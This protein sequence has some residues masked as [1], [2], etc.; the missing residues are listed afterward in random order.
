MQTSSTNRHYTHWDRLLLQAD[1]TL[2]TLLANYP[3]SDR[4]NPTNELT[5]T[6][7]TD[8]ERQHAAG[9]MRVNHVGEICAQALYQGQAITA[10]TPEIRDSMQEAATEEFDHL[11]WCKTRLEELES[12]PSYLN[13]LW[14]SGSLALGIL[15]GIAGDKWNLGFLAETERQVVKHLEHHLGELPSADLKSRAIVAQ[16]REDE[17]KHAEQAV[18]NGAVE[19]PWSIKKLMAAM[20]KVMTTLA[21]RI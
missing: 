11:A 13:P 21:Y 19:L 1:Q 2:R 8:K 12:R 15:A 16:M 3:T 6:A 7:L 10:R 20:S 9:L 17:C 4:P 18:V 5:E 14:Y